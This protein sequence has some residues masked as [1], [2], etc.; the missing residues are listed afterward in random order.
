[1][2]IKWIP[3]SQNIDLAAYENTPELKARTHAFYEHMAELEIP[4]L[5]HLGREHTI[6]PAFHDDA[7]QAYNDPALLKPLL[8]IRSAGGKKLKIIGAHCALPAKGDPEIGADGMTVW[9]KT[10]LAMMECDEYDNFHADLSAFFSNAAGIHGGNR[11]EAHR[12]TILELS[13]KPICKGK[14]HMGSDFPARS[15]LMAPID[16]RELDPQAFIKDVRLWNPLDHYMANFLEFGFPA[17]VMT[18]AEKVLRLP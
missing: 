11:L 12:Q 4:L 9:L 15:A 6:P 18:N 16:F 10:F 7:K 14:F 8:G 13:K 3:S 1:M 2:L 5:C 17:E